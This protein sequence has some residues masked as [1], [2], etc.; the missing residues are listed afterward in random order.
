MHRKIIGSYFN[1]QFNFQVIF[2]AKMPIILIIEKLEQII[3]SMSNTFG[4]V[5]KRHISWHFIPGAYKSVQI[6]KRNITIVLF[7]VVN[8]IFMQTNTAEKYKKNPVKVPQGKVIREWAVFI[9]WELYKRSLKHCEHPVSILWLQ[10]KLVFSLQQHCDTTPF[11]LNYPGARRAGGNAVLF[12]LLLSMSQILCFPL[13][14]YINP[15]ALQSSETYV[16]KRPFK[17]NKRL[18]YWIL[19]KRKQCH[20]Y[21]GLWNFQISK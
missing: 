19:I 21:I 12:L 9:R 14:L 15:Q 6:F 4:L 11:I 18:D 17:D 13:T 1:N 20:S 10:H 3:L 16:N 2:Y 8:I 7:K 5:W